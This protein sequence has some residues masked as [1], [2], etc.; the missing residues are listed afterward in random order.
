[1]EFALVVLLCSS[2]P[3]AQCSASHYETI[4]FSQGPV[5]RVECNAMAMSVMRKLPSPPD[6]QVYFG[7]CMREDLRRKLVAEHI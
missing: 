6:G 5:S 1:M 7:S 3:G 4:A 2:A